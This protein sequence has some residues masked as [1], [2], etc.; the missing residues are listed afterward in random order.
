MVKFGIFLD[1]ETSSLDSGKIDEKS[2]SLVKVQLGD[3]S[4]EGVLINAGDNKDN[5]IPSSKGMFTTLLKISQE[6]S[7]AIQELLKEV[8][9]IKNHVL[10]KGIANNYDNHN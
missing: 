4:L 2:I 8:S 9:F 7:Q 1:N 3:R 5:Q 6:C 10:G